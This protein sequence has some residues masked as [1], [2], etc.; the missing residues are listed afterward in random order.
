MQLHAS[1]LPIEPLLFT[2]YQIVYKVYFMIHKLSLSQAAL[3]LCHKYVYPSLVI[4]IIQ[5]AFSAVSYFISTVVEIWSS[6]VLVLH[7]VHIFFKYYEILIKFLMLFGH[8]WV[9]NT[10]KTR[11]TYKISVTY[12]IVTVPVQITPCYLTYLWC[13]E[14]VFLFSLQSADWG[15]W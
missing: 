10:C 12:I 1:T 9:T 6:S 13:M 8:Q 2:Y 7:R 5:L 15:N 3:I 11:C 14:L 4:Q